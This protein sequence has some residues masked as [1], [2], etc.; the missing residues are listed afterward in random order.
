MATKA[1]LRLHPPMEG[2]T[3]TGYHGKKEI[4]K[5]SMI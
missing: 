4:N 5:V 1:S 3:K 2:Q